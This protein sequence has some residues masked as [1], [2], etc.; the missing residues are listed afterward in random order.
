MRTFE[1]GGGGEG[2]DSGVLKEVWGEV[3]IDDGEEEE[4]LK[5]ERTLN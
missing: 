3:G 2:V 5:E 1:R 4:A